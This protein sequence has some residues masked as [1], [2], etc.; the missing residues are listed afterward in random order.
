MMKRVV[1]FLSAILF[2]CASGFCQS[3][4]SDELF[5]RGVKLY[6]SGKYHKAIPL[7]AQCDSLDR[8]EMDSRSNRIDYAKHWLASCYFH[9][10]D[11]ATAARLYDVY[12]TPPVDRRLTIESDSAAY[13]GHYYFNKGAYAEALKWFDKCRELETAIIGENHYYVAN[14]YINMANTELILGDTVMAAK[15][16]GKAADIRC[17]SLGVRSEYTYDATSYA[18]YVSMWIGDFSTAK[19][20][21]LKAME[22]RRL[23]SG[24]DNEAYLKLIADYDYALNQLKD[25]KSAADNEKEEVAIRERMAGKENIDYIRAFN[26]YSVYAYRSGQYDVSVRGLSEAITLQEKVLGPHNPNVLT[27]LNNLFRTYSKMGDLEGMMSVAEH[28]LPILDY[29]EKEGLTAKYKVKEG[30]NMEARKFLY[31]NYQRRENNEKALRYA[32]EYRDLLALK[33]GTE[34]ESYAEVLKDMGS[35]LNRMGRYDEALHTDSLALDLYSRLKGPE[36]RET[37]IVLNNISVV[38]FATNHR[39]EALRTAERVLELRR[40]VLGPNSGDVAFT[41]SNLAMMYAEAGNLERG[42][43]LGEQSLAI[44][45]QLSG[46]TSNESKDQHGMLSLIYA[47]QGRILAKQ[48]K[49]AEADQAYEKALHHAEKCYGAK[50]TSCADILYNRAISDIKRGYK[51]MAIAHIKEALSIYEQVEGGKSPKCA[52]MLSDLTFIYGEMNDMASYVHYAELSYA[53]HEQVYGLENVKTATA[54][55]TLGKAYYNCGDKRFQQSDSLYRRALALTRQTAGPRSPEYA[56]AHSGQ[57]G[58]AHV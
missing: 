35:M 20:Y 28:Q 30:V 7:F 33:Q 46:D 55:M 10:G 51:T 15:Y 40:K 19:D 34:T 8:H 32:Q 4:Q 36:D 31:T 2:L 18:S 21:M 39:D 1:L 45:Q 42:I 12:Y 38:L 50:S 54:M 17:A 48:L 37:L 29:V 25:W 27:N 9:V 24:T 5:A 6:K 41:L 58:R 44:C 14:D 11:T 43:E 13:W 47:E 3:R 22:C 52:E 56:M 49:P 23:L 57:I 26:N 16:Y 53:A